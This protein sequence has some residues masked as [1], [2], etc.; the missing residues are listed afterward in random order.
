MDNPRLA[1]RYAK[2]IVDLSQ[3]RNQLEV[4]C[5]D[6]KLLQS[7]C[8]S[9]PDFVSFLRSPIISA[10]KKDKIIESVLTGKINVLTSAFI[11][12]LVNKGREN[13]L[14]EIADAFID[15]YNEIKNIHRVKLTTAVTVSDELKQAIVDKVK[16][17]ASIQNIELETVVKEKLIGGFMLEMQDRLID[18]S[19]LRDL[20]D[21][22][23]QF[24]DNQYV[25]KIR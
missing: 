16:T 22:K 10:D 19:V 14:P 15:Q 20:H 11:K 3:E 2:S 6:M 13:Y 23:R 5:A 9:N 25:L 7:I 12:L 18:A 1:G 21:I 17:S 4:I 24:T 8:R